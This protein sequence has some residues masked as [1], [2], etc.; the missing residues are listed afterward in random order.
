MSARFPTAVLC[1]A[2]I[3][4]FV[5]TAGANWSETFDNGTF[6]LSSWLFRAYPEVTDTFDAAIE[7]GPDGNG[8]LVLT[9]TNPAN[10]GGSASGVGMGS[11]EE[12]G[13][14]RLGTAINLGGETSR[15]YQGLGVRMTYFIDDGSISGYPGIITSG[16]IMFVQWQEG[17]ANVRIEVLKI[18]NSEDVVMKTYVEVPVPGVDFS[19]PF[20]AELDAVGDGPVYITASLYDSKGGTLL[21]RTPTWIDTNAA[22]AWENPGVQDAVYAT[23]ASAVFMMNQDLNYPGYRGTFDDIYST[24][25]GPAAVA[26]M[27]ADEAQAV[28]PD[29]TLSWIEAAFATS[30]EVWFGPEGGMQRVDPAPSGTSFDPGFLEYGQTYQWRVDQVGSNGTVTGHTWTFT[31]DDG[32]PVE[33]FESYTDDADI[34]G[35]WVHN[36]EGYDYIFSET[37]RV[38]RGK[39]AMRFTYQNQYEPFRT[40]AARTFGAAQDWTRGDAAT[41]S[42]LFRGQTDNVEQAMYV[43]V[44]DSSGVSATVSLPNTYMVQSKFWRQWDI[45]LAEF[46]GVDLA[47]VAKLTIGFGDGTNSGQEMP[48]DL[49]TVY[50]DTIRLLPS[51]APG[52]RGD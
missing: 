30:R 12:F 20:Y 47:N 14:V 32:I 5:G 43:A 3:L 27:P 46:G 8:Y 15:S 16:Y 18:L 31:T 37:G 38:D 24:A 34:A 25:E 51:T 2:L 17:P 40:E 22:D 28:S 49:D 6:D 11:T 33:D 52:V 7:T 35:T 45:D 1:G 42:L 19:R 48:D 39:K 4:A 10:A 21:A 13:D 41:L 36:I 26:P 44:Q 23:G 50:I 9:E 29:T